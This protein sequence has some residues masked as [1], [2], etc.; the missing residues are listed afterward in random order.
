[1]NRPQLRLEDHALL[2]AIDEAIERLKALR[3]RVASGAATAMGDEPPERI[4][5]LRPIGKQAKNDTRNPLFALLEENGWSRGDL[6]RKVGASRGAVDLWINGRCIPS[7]DRA[8]K[9]EAIQPGL[10]AKLIVWKE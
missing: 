6:A 3:L 8:E 1:M 5:S 4:L 10:V 9:L 2:Y 7:G